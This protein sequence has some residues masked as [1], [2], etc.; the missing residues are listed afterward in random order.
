LA[1]Q[2][3]NY[4]YVNSEGA[5]VI[6]P[7]SSANLQLYI[8]TRAEDGMPVSSYRTYTA[9]PEELPDKTKIESDIK[10]MVSELAETKTAPLAD[11]Y[12]GPVLFVG[13]AVGELINQGVGVFLTARR[14]PASP[15][16]SPRNRENPLLEKINAK[17]A[18][19]FISVKAAPTLKNY[20][21][22]TLL[23]ACEVDDEGAPCL[24]VNLIE[25]GILK[26]LLTSRTPVKGFNKSNGH[27]RGG[28]IAPSVLQIVS[29]SKKP[30]S[31]L[32]Q[33]LMNAAKEEGLPFG[34]VVSGIAPIG[35]IGNAGDVLASLMSMSGSSEPNQF[36]LTSPYSIYRV[37]ADGKT[38]PVRGIEFGSI[39]I[40]VLKNILAT[41]DD[42][43]VYDFAIGSGHFATVITPSLLIN[44]IDMK[45]SSRIGTFSKLPIVS[46]PDAK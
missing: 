41:S 29:T 42:E 46:P 36:G 22:Q 4:Y 25:N 5:I 35:S 21:G 34:Y 15:N 30:F 39:N 31:E 14:M 23:G 27:G 6:E 37:Y 3:I 17:V 43:I 24:D 11:P 44:G 40:N 33:A 1:V 16:P 26:N 18:S 12:S 10:R 45:K 32:K 20:G 38:E 19:N 7:Y 9:R 8:T 13:Q 28:S 2:I